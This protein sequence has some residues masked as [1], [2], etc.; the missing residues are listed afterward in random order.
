MR[1]KIRPVVLCEEIVAINIAWSRPESW[2]FAT[3]KYMP[4]IDSCEQIAEQVLHTFSKYHVGF[5]LT[6]GYLTVAF[7]M[8]GRDTVARY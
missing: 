4:M 7:A 2:I 5:V 6:L 3:V 1:H 8:S